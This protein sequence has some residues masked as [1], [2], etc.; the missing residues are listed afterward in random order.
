MLHDRSINTQMFFN[1]FLFV[2]DATFP[3]LE[4]DW[5]SK[6]LN[7]FYETHGDFSSWFAKQAHL[8]Y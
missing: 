7:Y 3:K 6:Y 5:Q 1:H 4:L 2:L 8:D